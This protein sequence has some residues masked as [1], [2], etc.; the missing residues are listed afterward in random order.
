MWMF[1][2]QGWNVSHSSDLS[3]SGDN[4]RRS[5]SAHLSPAL[6]V[7]DINSIQPRLA[8]AP[9]QQMG[10]IEGRERSRHWFIPSCH[11]VHALYKAFFL[12]RA[13]SHPL[14]SQPSAWGTHLDLG[15]GTAPA[16]DMSPYL[17][18]TVVNSSFIKLFK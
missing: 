9:S 15:Q 14:P 17:V 11:R 10:N 16:S 3:H 7:W 8:P 4:A 13:G 2:D 1:L 5:I 6:S 18:H 12:S